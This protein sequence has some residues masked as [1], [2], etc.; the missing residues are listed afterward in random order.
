MNILLIH[1]AFVSDREA[2]GTRHYELAKRLQSQGDQVKI[3]ASQ[4]NYLTGQRIQLRRRQIVYTENINGIQIWRAYTIAAIHRSFV[5]RAFAF[6]VFAFTSVWAGLRVGSI[7]LVMGTTPP[8]FQAFSGLIVARIRRKP[9]LLEIRDLWPEFH[10]DMGVLKNPILIRVARFA[11][12]FLYN[13]STHLLVNSPAYQEYLVRKG[14]P[15][16]KISFVPNG[17]EIDMFENRSQESRA[18]IK[19]RYGLENKFVVTYA[20]ALG[21]ANDLGVLLNAANILKDQSNIHIMIVGDGKERVNLEERARAL[22]LSNVTFTGSIPKSQIPDMLAASDACVAILQNIP[23]FT[24]TYPNKVFDYM[25]AAKPT[26]CVIDGVIRQVIEA[27]HGGIFAQPGDPSALA[28]AI[29]T[30][31][32]DMSAAQEMGFS[33]KAYV[34]ANFNREDQAYKFRKVLQEVAFGLKKRDASLTQ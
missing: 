18:E 20:G 3:V 33:A 23:M 15:P 28:T 25:A 22:Q 11:E 32:R 19:T 27:A 26:I 6:I 12:R 21:I 14:I 17:V 7:D 4:V 24:T 29:L 9:Y 10:I 13:H 30:L 34:S 16:E 2:G 5:W 31:S 1:Q 8:L